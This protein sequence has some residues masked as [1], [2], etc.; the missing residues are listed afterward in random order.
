MLA[1]LRS[2]KARYA[3]LMC[4]DPLLIV[5]PLE[6]RALAAIAEADRQAGYGPS[7]AERIGSEPPQPEGQH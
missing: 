1:D 6:E 5:H 7:H 2:L 4:S 3:A